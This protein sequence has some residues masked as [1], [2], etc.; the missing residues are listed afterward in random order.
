MLVSSKEAIVGF[1]FAFILFFEKECASICV[2]G[3]APGGEGES[4]S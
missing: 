3:A 2:W 1:A 4:E